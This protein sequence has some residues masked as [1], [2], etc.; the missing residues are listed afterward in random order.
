MEMTLYTLV[1]VH[2][3]PVGLALAGTGA[4]PF[5]RRRNPRRI[6]TRAAALWPPVAMGGKLI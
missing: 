5:P 6:W 4:V 3:Q 1:Q 2:H